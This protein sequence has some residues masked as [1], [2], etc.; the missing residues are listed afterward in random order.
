VD[1]EAGLWDS[2]SETPSPAE[3]TMSPKTCDIELGGRFMGLF[4]GLNGS[5]KTIAG[6]SWPGE[7]LI[8]DWDGRVA[9]V[10]HFYPNRRDIEYWTIGLDG[11]RN[12]VLGFTDGIKKI[13]DLQDRC[14]YDWILFDSYTTYSATSVIHQMG[15][16]DHDV[17]RTKGGLPIPDWDEYKGETGVMLQILEV[18]KILPCNVIV[19]AHPIQAAKTTKQGGSANDVLASMIK[20]SSI[21]SYGWKTPS[22]LPNYFNEMYYFYAE[23][24]TQVG[25]IN[26][27]FCQTV[28]AGEIVCKTA[29]PL[30]PVMEITNAPLYKVIQHHLKEYEIKLQEKN[31]GKAA[32]NGGA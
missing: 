32:P 9:P 27:R 20:G 12:D 25:Q 4:V 5:G 13:E 1:K 11:A 3:E 16:H 30:P 7:G 31:A 24:S 10:R 26:R 19:T 23:A 2:S 15:M 21:A 6:A 28:S 8:L 22:L 14:P 17:K 18:L 29:L